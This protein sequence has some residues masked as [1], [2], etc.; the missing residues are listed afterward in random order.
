MNRTAIDKEVYPLLASFL[1]EVHAFS[2]NRK[3][4]VD[5]CELNNDI[6]EGQVNSED[7]ESLKSRNAMD[8]AMVL[9]DMKRLSRAKILE[10]YYTLLLV[11][12]PDKTSYLIAQLDMLYECVG[13][14]TFNI[15]VIGDI[16]RNIR[17]LIDEIK[18]CSQWQQGISTP[19]GTSV[20]NNNLI[21]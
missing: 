17:G 15:E 3:A 21:N 6:L 11:L 16:G 20:L 10:K 14:A 12:D 9:M 8:Q 13:E 4:L 7:I 2:T 5:V 18:G 1:A 19:E